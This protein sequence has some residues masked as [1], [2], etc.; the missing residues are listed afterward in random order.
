MNGNGKRG[1][2]V[3]FYPYGR[4]S[5]SLYIDGKITIQ[6]SRRQS[7]VS[8]KRTEVIGTYLLCQKCLAIGI[9]QTQ[10]VRLSFK[11]L[12]LIG[13]LPVGNAFYIYRLTG[14][15]N[16][17][18]GQQRHPFLRNLSTICLITATTVNVL[19]RHTYITGH[20]GLVETYIRIPTEYGFSTGTGGYFGQLLPVFAG[21]TGI[22]CHLGSLYWPTAMCIHHTYFLLIIRQRK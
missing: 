22:E 9:E 20:R 16:G 18:V 1:A 10:Y 8:G 6:A 15:V 4:R 7:K 14:T 19:Q 11:H 13:L 2:F 12:S 5:L 21:V 3:F 17:P